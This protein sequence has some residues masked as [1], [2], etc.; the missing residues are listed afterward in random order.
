MSHELGFYILLHVTE[1]REPEDI[2]RLL[3]RVMGETGLNQS[4]IARRS[5]IPTATVSAW[6][7]GTRVPSSGQEGRAKL[8]ALAEA[9]PGVTVAEVFDAAGFSTPGHLTPDA[10]QRILELYRNLSTGR[11]KAALQV[12]EALHAEQGSDS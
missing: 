10:E 11:Q 6:A 4:D 2:A 3:Q 12:V 5:G 8:R 7:R 1:N 9:I